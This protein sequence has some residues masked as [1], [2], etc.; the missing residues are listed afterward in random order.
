MEHGSNSNPHASARPSSNRQ[1]MVRFRGMPTGFNPFRRQPRAWATLIGAALGTVL[2]SCTGSPSIPVDPEEV[3]PPT[4]PACRAL[5]AAAPAD[6]P[7]RWRAVKPHGAA[8]APQLI[9]AL[10]DNPEGPGA[11]AAIHLLGQLGAAGS[12]EFLEDVLDDG[13]ALGAEAALALGRLAA[14]ASA[15]ALRRAVDSPIYPIT[16]RVAAAA[17]LVRMG[18]G[19]SVVGFLQAVFL[20]ASPYGAASTRRHGIPAKK[21]RWALERYM[22]IEA[23]RA[24]YPTQGFDLDEDSSWPA[25][26]DAAAKMAA[27]L[28]N[29]PPPK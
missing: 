21:S 2:A 13:N 24:R 11:Q 28:E 27:F 19:K 16:T 18:R 25:M 8:V 20:A 6:W 26:R 7:A 1:A 29:A 12:R 5:V 22:V 14:P 4:L 17:G 9:R 23:L 10:Q 3:T 15:A